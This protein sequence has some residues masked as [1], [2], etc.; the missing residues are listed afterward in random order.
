MRTLVSIVAMLVLLVACGSG[1]GTLTVYSGRSE[2]LIGPLLDRFTAETG[3]EVEVRYGSSADLALVIDQEADRSPADV[4]IS[5][6]PGAVGFLAER[7]R[8]EPVDP[9][10]LDMV[11]PQFHNT[12]GLWVG[13]SGRARVLVYNTELVDP[14]EL[15]SSIFDLTDA[16]YEGKVALAPANG[17]FQDFVTAMRE[18]EGDDATLG[19]LEAMA[20]NNSPEYANNSAIVEAVGRGEVPM[21]LV[22][23]YYNFRALAEDPS[24]ASQNYYFPPGDVGGLVVVTAAG[25]VAGTDQ[26]DLARQFLEYMLSEPAQTFLT[27]ETFEYPLAIG[28][29]PREG[30]PPLADV[31]SLTYDFDRLGGGLERTKELIDASGLE[32]P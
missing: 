31:G 22:N 18:L 14:A 11:D 25:V 21:G 27:E 16:R 20:D 23:H 7:D 15:P 13:L 8:L 29:Q 4:F 28:A 9:S 1:E 10:V 5:Q 3:I 2:E 6:S 26:A 24:L 12:D 19:W 32:G 17:S 30:L